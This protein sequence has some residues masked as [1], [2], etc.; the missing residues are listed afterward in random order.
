MNNKEKG[1]LK[2]GKRH[3]YLIMVH[4]NPYTF[5]KL[6]K[7]LDDER[8]DI[9]VHVDAKTKNYPIERV[10]AEM[11]YSAVHLVPRIK[12]SWGGYSQIRTE[13]NLLKCAVKGEYKYYHLISGVDMPLKTQDQIYDFFEKAEEKEFLGVSPFTENS[14]IY[15]RIQFYYFFQEAVGRGRGKHILVFLEK[16]LRHIQRYIG[17]DRGAKLTKRFYGAT[18]FDITHDFAT[19]VLSKEKEIEKQYKYTRCAD[20]IFMQSILMDSHFKSQLNTNL[21]RE[22]DWNRGSPYTYTKDD[23]GLLKSSTKMFARKF[24]DDKSE[25]VDMIY[26]DLKNL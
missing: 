5:E 23:Y 3:A 20:E 18:W 15:Y 9:Y 25:I 2:N 21:S 19:Y 12:V 26:E 8:N 11:K 10:K 22:I 16:L 13:L 24:S 1:T 6:M 7:L 17:T 14:D 4:N